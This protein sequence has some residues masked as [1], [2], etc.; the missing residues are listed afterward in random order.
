M[1]LSTDSARENVA[2]II[3]RPWYVAAMS[4]AVVV[5]SVA[6]LISKGKLI[7]GAAV[8]LTFAA[9]F[10]LLSVSQ[11]TSVSSG[12][13]ARLRKGAVQFGGRYTLWQAGRGDLTGGPFANGAGHSRFG[14]LNTVVENR[15]I[16]FGH[17]SSEAAPGRPMPLESRH[18][19]VALR[20]PARLPHM[21]IDFGRL[22][23]FFG[24]RLAPEKR[25]R[26][27]LVDVGGGH[28]FRLF[29]A[30]DGEQ[31]ARAFFTPEMVRLFQRVGRDYDVEFKDN[32][33]YLFSRRSAA[34]GSER[35][36]LQQY[37]LIAEV[38]TALEH[39]GIWNL[40]QRYH[41]GRPP[42]KEELR[43]D[44][45][46]AVTIVVWAAVIAFVA[47]TALALYARE[48]GLLNV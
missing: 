45:K 41:R 42:V 48:L 36:W 4:G 25:H 13:L 2:A 34:S 8:I 30:D 14:I 5:I 23:R 39:S 15:P 9:L 33:V 35:R 24:V 27:Q 11:L 29:V 16:E 22:S 47:L 43:V 7:A 44:E 18:A 46:C 37:A 31:L 26:S 17:L 6:L 28:R 3:R 10:L 38:A 19:Y 21:A 20:L 40:M 32:C 12:S 1:N